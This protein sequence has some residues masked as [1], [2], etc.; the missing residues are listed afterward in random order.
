MARPSCLFYWR[1]SGNDKIPQNRAQCRSVALLLN[2]VGDPQQLFPCQRQLLGKLR[3]TLCVGA[4]LSR[5]LAKIK[6]SATSKSKAH[7]LLWMQS[8][9]PIKFPTKDMYIYTSW[10]YSGNCIH[11]IASLSSCKCGNQTLWL[12]CTAPSVIL[13][14]LV[15]M[16]VWNW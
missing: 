16:I 3:L 15:L 9:F 2:V 11:S 4:D 1:G 6:S 5:D 12:K 10:V 8:A 14:F 7:S 13:Y